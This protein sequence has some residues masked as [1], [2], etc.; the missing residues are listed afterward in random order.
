MF[1]LLG[2]GEGDRDPVLALDSVDVAVGAYLVVVSIAGA[3]HLARRASGLEL[4]MAD[5]AEDATRQALFGQTESWTVPAGVAAALSIVEVAE[6]VAL[7]G[8][9]ALLLLPIVLAVHLPI[10]VAVWTIL[11]VVVSL[12]RLGKLPLEL[13]PYS[14][15]PNMG[16][17]R[18]GVLAYRAFLLL[19]AGAAPVM[20][21]Y[22]TNELSLYLNI[23][24][25][26]A[27]ALAFAGSLWEIHRKMEGARAEALK[28]ARLQVA[29][30]IEEARP[31]SEP[32]EFARHAGAIALAISLE[33]R[34]E[35]VKTW[36]VT[37][38]IVGQFVLIVISVV[39]G[40]VSRS[41]MTVVGL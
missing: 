40:L 6:A 32:D 3:G 14:G 21:R 12:Y 39:T 10:A 11:T 41:V 33:E 37:G 34:V 17:K 29:R 1:E 38:G 24:L 16:L 15:D 13:D 26:V 22:T 28:T 31:H 36:P 9:P 35:S 20:I 7:T 25:I 19:A 18:A 27:V 4:P 23:P 2:L 30:L 8:I 5:G